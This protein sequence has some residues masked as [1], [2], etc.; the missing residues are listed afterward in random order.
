MKAI[1]AGEHGGY[2][3]LRLVDMPRPQ[4]QAGQALV[5]VTS[6]GVTPLDRTVLAGL[7][8]RAAA[9]PL[10]PGNE[11]AGVVIEDPAGRF[12]AGE[13]VL[14]FAGPGGVTQ[15]GTFAELASV[16]SGNLAPL[17]AEIPG[18][19]ASGLPVPYL[20]AFLALRQA[21]FRAGQSVLAP[22]V[23]GSVGN[24]TLKV[25]RALGASQLLSTAGSPAKEAAAAADGGLR[26]VD[27]VN[28]ERESLADGLARLA[29]GGVDVVIDA[30]GGAITG[31]A[32]GGLAR[33]GRLV[34]MGYAAGTETTMRVTDLVWKL[35]RVSGFSLFAASA[36]E[37]A[38]AYAAVLPLIAS[39]E[40][41]PAH[42][43]SFP[44]A[45]APEALRHLIEDRPFGTVTLSVGA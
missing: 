28:L 12:S 37:Q 23:G 1:Q 29:P 45:Q 27:I 40:I 22:G 41:T 34:V 3:A 36:Q 35:A 43:R 8:P 26:R 5:R 18:E 33:G 20:S 21:G 44:L 2:E 13:R 11:G 19:I 15:D 32:V 39:G 25:A 10:V 24:A 30:L 7:H 6:A 38:E 16:P 9:P 4:P 17:P 31:Q 42:D 14:F